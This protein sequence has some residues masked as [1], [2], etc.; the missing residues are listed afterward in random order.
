MNSLTRT[1]T[2]FILSLCAIACSGWFIDETDPIVL[3]DAYI[4]VEAL[5]GL[6]ERIERLPSVRQVNMGVD[7]YQDGTVNMTMTIIFENNVILLLR[8]PFE[9]QQHIIS[10]AYNRLHP[11]PEL[12]EIH[13]AFAN[14][15]AALHGVPGASM[16]EER[17]Q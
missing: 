4:P 17:I 6:D 8:D 14:L 5:D 11:H 3:A 2:I 1:L 15:R 16:S 7:R 12:Q 13:Y 9:P 10:S